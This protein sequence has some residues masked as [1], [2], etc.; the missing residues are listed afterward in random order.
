M[1]NPYLKYST[2]IGLGKG[3]TEPWNNYA[4]ILIEGLIFVVY[5]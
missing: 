2:F 3:E 4:N 1:A 5:H